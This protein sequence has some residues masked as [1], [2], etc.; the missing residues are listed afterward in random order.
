MKIKLIK[1]AQS[2]P[3]DFPSDLKDEMIK[4]QQ[5][6][7]LNKREIALLEFYNRVLNK[8]IPITTEGYNSVGK[9][10][11]MFEELMSDLYF[12][13]FVLL[14]YHTPELRIGLL[15][16]YFLSISRS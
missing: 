13:K 11:G 7:P 3:L 5:E 8:E 15:K 10:K 1:N 4:Q 9:S 14:A 12:Q 6:P 2:N 16:Q